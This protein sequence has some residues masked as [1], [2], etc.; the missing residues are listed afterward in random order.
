MPFSMLHISPSSAPTSVEST[1]TGRLAH[2][3]TSR[4]PMPNDARPKIEV[5]DVRIR[6]GNL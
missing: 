2:L 1:I 6:S 3:I 4:M 5:I